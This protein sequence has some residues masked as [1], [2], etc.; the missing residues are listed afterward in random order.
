A[1]RWHFGGSERGTAPRAALGDTR[2]IVRSPTV[3]D[4]RRRATDRPFHPTVTMNGMQTTGRRWDSW[5]QAAVLVGV[6]VAVLWLLEILDTLTANSL[7]EY[8]VQ[9]RSEEGLVGVVLAPMLHFGFDHLA[10]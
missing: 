8:G 4:P 1:G 3:D 7:D 6:F 9:P 10:S 5:Q 2:A